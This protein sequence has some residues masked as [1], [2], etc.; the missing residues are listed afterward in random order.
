MF[1][2]VFNL[3]SKQTN[4]SPSFYAYKRYCFNIHDYI[5]ICIVWSVITKKCL[6]ILKR[7][8]LLGKAMF[9]SAQ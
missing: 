5:T 3:I 2:F 7:P 6:V 4:S 9:Y 8:E 1:C